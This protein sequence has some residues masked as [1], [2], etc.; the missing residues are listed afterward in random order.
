MS[1][2]IHIE[3]WSFGLGKLSGYVYNHPYYPDGTYLL[4]SY[5]ILWIDLDLKQAK[6]YNKEYTLGEQYN[7]NAHKK[8]KRFA[9]YAEQRQSVAQH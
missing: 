2:A 1:V 8:H 7:D 5:P 6:D 4:E 9:P 3:Q